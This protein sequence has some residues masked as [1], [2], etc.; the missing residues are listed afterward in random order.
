VARRKHNPAAYAYT[1]VATAAVEPEWGNSTCSAC[2]A[3]QYWSYIQVIGSRRPELSWPRRVQALPQAV[4]RRIQPRQF[5]EVR[6][7][8][9]RDQEQSKRHGEALDAQLLGAGS[10]RRRFAVSD[11][12][13]DG[14]AGVS[15]GRVRWW[16]EADGCMWATSSFGGHGAEFGDLAV[17][18]LGDFLSATDTLGCSACSVF[19]R[20]LFSFTMGMISDIPEGIG[21]AVHGIIT[22]RETCWSYTSHSNE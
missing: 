1:K 3:V 17:F 7:E 14:S 20:C 22:I 12:Y 11:V 16:E 10:E 15:L 13:A 5:E 4:P 19:C 21:R 2:T 8:G 6:E 18:L 9:R